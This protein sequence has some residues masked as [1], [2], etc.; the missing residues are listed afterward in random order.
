[1]IASATA[2][3]PS[4]TAM[5]S[6]HG[7]SRR[8]SS[9]TVRL[10]L[11]RARFPIPAGHEVAELLHIRALPVELAHELALVHDE[12]PIRERADLVQVLAHE[13]D[14]HSLRRRI[15]Q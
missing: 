11:G 14:G 15:A 4:G 8:R 2:T 10:S 1:M 5:A 7:C 6:H 3:D 13:E 12:D 9:L